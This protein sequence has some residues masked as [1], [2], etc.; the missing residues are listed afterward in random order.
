M[1]GFLDKDLRVIDAAAIPGIHIMG[2]EIWPWGYFA[3]DIP[4]AF[5]GLIEVVPTHALYS[6]ELSTDAH[7]PKPPNLKTLNPY[8]LIS[9]P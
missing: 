3:L 6:A 5:T 7:S 9:K 1:T 8:T 2:E 4:V